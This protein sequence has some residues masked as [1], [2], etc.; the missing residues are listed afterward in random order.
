[1]S[2]ANYS[3]WKWSRVLE[4]IIGGGLGIGSGVAVL[5]AYNNGMLAWVVPYR[6]VAYILALALFVLTLLIRP[7]KKSNKRKGVDQSNYFNSSSQ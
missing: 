3:K 5:L 1:M 6:W 4:A 2:H 7:P